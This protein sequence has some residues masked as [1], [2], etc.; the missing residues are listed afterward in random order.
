M[1][2]KL[3]HRLSLAFALTCLAFSANQLFAQSTTSSSPNP[4]VT[5]TNPEPQT[6]TGTNP[7]PQ[8]VVALAILSAI[9]GS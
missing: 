9:L 3:A 2:K 7:E 6:V 1:I 5:G 4:S 8:T